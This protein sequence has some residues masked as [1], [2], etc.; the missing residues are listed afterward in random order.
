MDDI[1]E[2]VKNFSTRIDE[3]EEVRRDGSRASAQN[4]GER[5]S[6]PFPALWGPG[7]HVACPLDMASARLFLLWQQ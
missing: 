1:Y 7:S 2:F 6:P 3:V 5:D 4:P